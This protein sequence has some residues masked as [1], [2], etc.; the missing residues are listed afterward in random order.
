MNLLG[1]PKL[2]WNAQERFKLQTPFFEYLTSSVQ[3]TDN[4]EIML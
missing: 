3:C 4:Q 1:M 2:S